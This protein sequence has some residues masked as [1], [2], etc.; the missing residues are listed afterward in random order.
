MHS[1]RKNDVEGAV[2]AQSKSRKIRTVERDDVQYAAALREQD[3]GRIGQIDFAIGIGTHEGC[4]C[5]FVCGADL[6]HDQRAALDHLKQRELAVQ[7]KEVACFG[8]YRPSC[9]QP[10]NVVGD[11][12]RCFPVIWVTIEQ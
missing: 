6:G 2:S 12:Q 5:R 9:R 4:E 10:I 8:D 1:F 11:P 3:K 7:F